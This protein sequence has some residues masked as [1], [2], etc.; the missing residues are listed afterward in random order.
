MH[1][2]T[3]EEL[4]SI[5]ISLTHTLQTLNTLQGP[6]I[7]ILARTRLRPNV[8]LDQGDQGIPRNPSPSTLQPSD[9]GMRSTN[10]QESMNLG[11][12]S[13]VIEPFIIVNDS[14]R[15]RQPSTKSK[16][17]KCETFKKALRSR[18]ERQT[19]LHV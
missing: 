1:A 19:M 17:K 5:F 10:V 13:V 7:E 16:K 18:K 6:F 3:P 12:T 4:H 2:F 14:W 9:I 11:D 8:V 15:N